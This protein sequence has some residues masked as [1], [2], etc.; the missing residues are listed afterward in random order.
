MRS[1]LVVTS[2]FLPLVQAQ[3]T[4]R[5]AEPRLVVVDH[6]VGGLSPDELAGRTDTAYAGVVAE[7]RSMGELS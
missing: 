2:S 6:P 5:R 7:L 1:I 3:A 4:A